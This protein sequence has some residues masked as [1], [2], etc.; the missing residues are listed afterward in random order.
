MQGDEVKITLENTHYLPH[1]IHL[2]G[3]DHPFQDAEGEG[4]DGVP[5]IS[6][7]PVMPGKSRTYNIKPRQP[8]TMFY[9][10]HVQP[11]SHLLMG[12]NG[13]FIV[14]ENRPNNLLQTLNVGAGHVRHPSVAVRERY[15]REYD[16]H[17]QGVGN[18]HC[19]CR[20][21]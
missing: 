21:R 13:M 6:E 7:L 9:H 1:T 15:A 16:L 3:V 11:Q 10:C 18:R 20:R 14:E 19:A 8:G 12:L 17:Y 5:Q 2:H 4:N